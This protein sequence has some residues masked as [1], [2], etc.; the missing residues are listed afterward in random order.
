MK[1]FRR[2][3]V[4]L[5]VLAI[6]FCV[7]YLLFNIDLDLNLGLFHTRHQ[8]WQTVRQRATTTLLVPTAVKT[9]HHLQE[10]KTKYFV[11]EGKL[12]CFDEGTDW[13]RTSLVNHTQCYCHS[14][15][16]NKQQQQHQLLQQ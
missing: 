9:Q 5:T 1:I 13:E 8:S 11:T 12:S 4:L 2:K 6:M 16:F 3:R 15:K 7:L 14:G 10:D